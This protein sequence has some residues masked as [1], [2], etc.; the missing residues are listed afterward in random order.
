MFN[1]KPINI[2]VSIIY[3]NIHK[4]LSTDRG[5]IASSN[6]YLVCLYSQLILNVSH[7]FALKRGQGKKYMEENRKRKNGNKLN[8]NPSPI[9][10]FINKSLTC[11]HFSFSQSLFTFIV[12][13]THVWAYYLPQ[14]H[15]SQ[16]LSAPC[17]LFLW[18]FCCAH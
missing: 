15:Y 5:I 7:L 9:S 8:L 14:E 10:I 6:M 1:L 2:Q 17:L 11:S 18:S 13:S 4:P 16:D 3:N 12:T